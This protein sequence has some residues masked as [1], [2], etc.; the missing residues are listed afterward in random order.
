M[1]KLFF[2]ITTATARAP[3]ETQFYDQQTIRIRI[4]VAS[5]HPNGGANFAVTAELWKFAIHY[6]A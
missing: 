2:M 1:A 4:F 5:Y 6:I 3:Q